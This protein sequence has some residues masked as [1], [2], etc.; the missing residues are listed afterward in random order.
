M[1]IKKRVPGPSPFGQEP[2]RRQ[3]VMIAAAQS[4]LV[5]E[6]RREMNN[7]ATQSARE[8][9]RSDNEKVVDLSKTAQMVP[10]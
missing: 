10:Q 6:V 8:A 2:D 4:K 1:S 7:I 3:G 5:N 9:L